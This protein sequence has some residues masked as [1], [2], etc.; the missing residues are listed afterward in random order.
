MDKLYYEILWEHDINQ[1]DKIKIFLFI[2][3]IILIFQCKNDK[4]LN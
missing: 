1:K 4:I 3:I 2:I